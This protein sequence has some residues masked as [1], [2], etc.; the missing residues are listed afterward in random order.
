[1]RSILIFFLCTIQISLIAFFYDQVSVDKE[2]YIKYADQS[3]DI[4]LYLLEGNL[5]KLLINEPIWL[6]LNTLLTH[7]TDIETVPLYIG[8]ISYVISVLYII[9]KVDKKYTIF[10]LLLF[11]MPQIYKSYLVHLRQGLGIS[12]YLMS[13]LVEKKR[14]K[15]ILIF[16][17][18]LIHNSFIPILFVHSM[19]ELLLRKF[20]T[21]S[22]IALSLILI[23]II[24]FYLFD[25][26]RILGFRQN[27]YY[28]NV[29]MNNSGIGF[30]FWFLIFFIFLSCRSQII[31]KNLICIIPLSVYLIFYFINPVASRLFESY[32][33]L[34]ISSIIY[35]SKS[36]FYTSY[37][38]LFA[39][40]IFT[41]LLVNY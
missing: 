25:I 20:S 23:F 1:M 36:K 22:I 32:I 30:L 21:R 5:Y 14:S 35:L 12:I 9:K 11:F 26:L 31:R 17:S 39:W 28:E 33:I 16:F 41:N 34:I 29:V 8:L 27:N 18:G 2:N 15:F 24:A 4:L 3:R 38:L 7:I 13:F 19:Y 6:L 37:G 40:T 10:L